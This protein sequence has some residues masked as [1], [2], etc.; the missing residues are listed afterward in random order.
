[1]QSKLAQ[2]L[3]MKLNPVA[4]IW[5][6]EKPEGAMQFQKDK[7]GCVMM[8]FAQVAK[9][10]TAVFDRE[11]F[12]CF[13][14]GVGLGFS[15]QYKNFFGGEECFFRYLS[16]GNETVMDDMKSDVVDEAIW[17]REATDDFIHGERYVKT[18]ELVRRFVENMPII[19][20]PAKYVIF[21]PLK[22]VD[23]DIDK[24][25]VIVFPVNPDQLSALVV[26]A[27]YAREV[28]DN[29]YAP[30]AAGCQSI[31]IFAYKETESENPRAIIGLTDIS[32]RNYTTRQL[33]K[34]ILT[35]AVPT[36]MFHEMEENVEG[37][38][39]QRESWKKLAQQ[40]LED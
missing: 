17:R 13:G 38:F 8:L 33:G 21:K 37:S 30:F 7:W 14:G 15:N 32:A 24:P 20:V 29:V 28:N 3:K 27:N 1:M 23:E 18:P 35:F 16:T 10:K 5:S 40:N 12:A 11:T 4:I 9:G 19:D 25:V 34:D 6:D 2:H 22:D 31:G 26:M 39:L 36:K